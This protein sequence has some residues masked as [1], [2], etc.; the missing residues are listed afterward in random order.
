MDIFVATESGTRRF[1]RGQNYGYVADG[2]SMVQAVWISDARYQQP[3]DDLIEA[4]QMYLAY[5]EAKGHCKF[6]VESFAALSKANK[7]DALK[8]IPQP[9]E[10]GGYVVSINQDKFGEHLAQQPQTQ[11][12]SI[13][14][15]SA[16]TQE[17]KWWQLWK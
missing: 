6:T 5:C 17:K 9:P 14:T 3:H 13:T 2:N 7:W 10:I 16:Q 12:S 1:H 4:L 11:C 15:R 8:F